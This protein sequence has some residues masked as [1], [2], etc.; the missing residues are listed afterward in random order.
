MRGNAERILKLMP[1]NLA[2][3]YVPNTTIRQ[4]RRPFRCNHIRTTVQTRF[5][6]YS[7]HNLPR[8]EGA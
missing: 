3:P 4:V 1:A 8:G 5:D 2:G 6:R 7:S